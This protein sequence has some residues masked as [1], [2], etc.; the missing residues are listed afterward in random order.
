MDFLKTCYRLLRASDGGDD[1]AFVSVRGKRLAR[2]NPIIFSPKAKISVFIILLIWL[3]VDIVNVDVYVL[4]LM[5][6]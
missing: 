3:I 6:M 2:S 4:I 1:E 5:L